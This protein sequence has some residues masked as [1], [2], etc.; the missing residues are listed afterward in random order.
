MTVYR[1][2]LFIKEN[3]MNQNLKLLVAFLV[4]CLFI[5]ACNLPSNAPGEIT[6]GD[7]SATPTPVAQEIASVTP[8]ATAAVAPVASC[9]GTVTTNTDANVRSGPG[10]V[11]SVLGVIPQGGTAPVA[12]KNF[13]GTWW[14]IQFAAG[15]GGHAWIASSVTT[16][17]CIPNELAVISAPPTPVIPTNVP[18]STTAP[19]GPSP[20]P[21]FV[22]DPGIILVDPGIFF[23]NTPTP[24][25]FVVFE[26]PTICFWLTC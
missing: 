3:V 5:S 24:T 13:D 21:G 16:A 22:F 1:P 9:I 26:V 25:P 10:Q 4:L 7:A 8:T 6:A 18:T 14:Y 12:G 17:T 11:Y 23:I 15:S 19:G 20:T 2:L